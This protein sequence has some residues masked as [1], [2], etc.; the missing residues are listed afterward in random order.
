MQFERTNDGG[1]NIITPSLVDP[2]F[3]PSPSPQVAS[4]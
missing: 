4:V 1:E 3:C 2:L